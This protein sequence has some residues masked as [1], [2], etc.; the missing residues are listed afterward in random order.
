MLLL[1]FGQ[2]HITG[3]LHY[4]QEL[5][6]DMTTKKSNASD[7]VQVKANKED[8]KRSV[9]ANPKRPLFHNAYNFKFNPNT[10]TDKNT[11]PSNTVPG[12][13]EEMKDMFKR[14]QMGQI[15]PATNYGYGDDF[16]E[17]VNP[18]YKPGLDLTDIDN[19]NKYIKDLEDQVKSKDLEGEEGKP[20]EVAP[21][22]SEETEEKVIE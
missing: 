8:K 19:I 9:S 6:I 16:G 13:V 22:P 3:R 7:T 12:M 18:M 5:D 2:C 20:S 21:H 15:V 10:M 4:K 17:Q 11:K 1:L 14:F